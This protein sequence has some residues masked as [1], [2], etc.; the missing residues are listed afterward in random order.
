[1]AQPPLSVAIRQ[2]EDE[3]GT[4]LFQRTTRE[5][6]LTEAGRALLDGAR[7]TLAEAERAVA[8]ARRAGAGE[9]GTLRIGFSWSARFETL[10]ALGQA[11]RARRPEVD[12]LTEEIWNARM[13][14][15]LREGRIDLAVAICP[16][17]AGGL[18]YEPIRQERIV[19]LLAATHRLAEERAIDVAALAGE[20]FVLFPRELAPRLHD[21]LIAVCRRGG[22][23]PTVRKESFH[24][25]WDLG[26]LAEVPVVALTP[27]SVAQAL[28]AG[29]L[30]VPLA[31]P[32]ARLETSLVS[33]SDDPSP[34][35]A[36]FVEVARGVFNGGSVVT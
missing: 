30:A 34:V 36:T 27:E 13:A 4:E 2:L 21:T 9:L 1:M 8:A 10:P 15:A 3:L 7:R 5:V 28:P 23:E 29:V 20:Q 18:A 35:L 19:A 33:R 22:F 16:E 26:V 24:A 25:G 32:Q 31:E 17:V 11:F 6:R 14:G 12:L